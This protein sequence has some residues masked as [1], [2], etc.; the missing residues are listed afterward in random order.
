MKFD[1]A[2][3]TALADALAP[4]VADI[5]EARLS[6]RPE[7]AFSVSEAAAWANVPEESIRH[8]IRSGKLPC[9]RV[10]NNVRIRRCDLFGLAA[11]K[12]EPMK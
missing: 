9:L 11:G 12:E 5:L 7:W 1:A 10:G 4:A 2:E 8:A 6:E 3:I